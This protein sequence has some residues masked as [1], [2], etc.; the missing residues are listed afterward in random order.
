[1]NMTGIIIPVMADH[2]KHRATHPA[3]LLSS[4]QMAGNG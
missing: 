1:M 3:Y 4:Q 2:A